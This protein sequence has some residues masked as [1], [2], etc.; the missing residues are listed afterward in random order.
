MRVQEADNVA[1]LLLAGQHCRTVE[2]DARRVADGSPQ[3]AR[4]PQKT[5]ALADKGPA[6]LAHSARNATEGVPY[7]ARLVQRL[8][9]G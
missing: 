9:G 2:F 6:F 4:E 1:A 8:R 7:S 3:L 5:A